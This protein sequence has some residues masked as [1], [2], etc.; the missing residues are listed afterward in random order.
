MVGRLTAHDPVDFQHQPTVH[1]EKIRFHSMIR[2]GN[3]VNQSF[4]SLL[5]V[6]EVR[7]HSIKS[8]AL[9]AWPWRSCSGPSYY[10]FGQGIARRC[11]SWA[12]RPVTQNTSA[13]LPGWRVCLLP[14]LLIQLPLHTV[15]PLQHRRNSA[16]N[17]KT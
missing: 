15:D 11:I 9:L 12:S 13:W 7:L 4:V 5:A 17:V 10:Y 3:E 16:K 2:C 14:L 1:R 6:Q 8:A